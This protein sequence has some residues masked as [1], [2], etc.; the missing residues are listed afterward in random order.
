M[1]AETMGA[2]IGI[3]SEEDR[4]RPDLS[5][6]E[7]LWAGIDKARRLTDW[8]PEHGGREGFMRGMAKTVEWFVDPVNLGFYK[9]DIYAV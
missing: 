2:K 9:P 3:V 7:R 6:V 5:E 8:A 4:M 1:I